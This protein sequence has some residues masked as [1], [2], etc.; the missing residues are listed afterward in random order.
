MGPVLT[1]GRANV[2]PSSLKT[3]AVLLKGAINQCGPWAEE[4]LV[5]RQ[6]GRPGVL[7]RKP[8]R[9]MSM[10]G[11]GCAECVGWAF[12]AASPLPN[13]CLKRY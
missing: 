13:S 3:E 12:A 5:W 4:S 8:A 9:P 11:G 10:A 2:T 6:G 1:R 7:F